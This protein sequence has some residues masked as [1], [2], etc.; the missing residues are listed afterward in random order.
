MQFCLKVQHKTAV[1]SQCAN[2]VEQLDVTSYC[3]TSQTQIHDG[4]L[5]FGSTGLNRRTTNWFNIM[6]SNSQALKNIIAN[7]QDFPQWKDKKLAP[8]E[9]S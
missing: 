5:N 1:K 7:C 8:R 3:E 4:G 6:L 2:L 9:K